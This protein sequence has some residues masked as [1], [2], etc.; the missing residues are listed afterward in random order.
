VETMGLEPTT[1]CLQSRFRRTPTDADG[2]NLLVRRGAVSGA[3]ASGRPWMF[4]KCSFDVS[5]GCCDGDRRRAASP[6]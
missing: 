2:P 6:V 1:P 4:P 3:D 5:R